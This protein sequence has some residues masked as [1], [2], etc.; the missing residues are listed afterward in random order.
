M[1]ADATAPMRR[2]I[3]R[4]LTIVAVAAVCAR[5]LSVERVYEPSIHREEP[6][7]DPA[8]IAL[9]LA[10]TSLLDTT[11]FVAAAGERWAWIDPN[12]PTRTWAHSRPAPS[13]TFSSNDRSRWAMVRALVDEGTF[14]I[15][16]RE[17]GPSGKYRDVGIVFEDGWQSIDKVLHPQTKLYYSSKPPLLPVIAAGEYWLLQKLFAWRIEKQTKRVVCTILLTIN[18]L[19][20]AIYLTVLARLIERYGRTDWG[21][22]F[23]FAA[24][25]FATYLTTFANTFNNHTVAA[26]TTLFAVAPLLALPAR[27]GEGRVGVS[28]TLPGR[29]ATSGFFAGLTACFELP[30]AAFLVALGVAALIIDWRRTL[31]AFV[32]AA[33][34][35]IAAHFALNYAELGDWK[36]AYE[37]IDSEW[38][39]YEGSHWNAQGVNRR[40]IDYAGDQESRPTYAF[41]LLL[42]HHGLFSLT[43]IW[44]LSAAGLT[45][46]LLARPGPDPNWRR[47]QWATAAVSVIVIVFFAAIVST[48]NYG[49]WTS[50]PRWFFWLTPLWL[51]ALLPAADR[52][53]TRAGR[54]VAYLALALSVFSVTFVGINP[55]RHP[56]VYQAMEAWGWKGY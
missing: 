48:V 47:V 26:Y 4:L 53:T 55:W 21:R 13:P 43:P 3:Y 30:A 15:G 51:L 29:F 50:G 10:A 19:P 33:L 46:T 56:W 25:C 7:P 12:G 24:A 11:I 41:H 42:G 27:V 31:L 17:Y 23:T 20:F 36:P 18:A 38:Y 1:N 14:A 6:P 16:R 5:I 40:G 28:W 2:N 44:L 37:K 32:P 52:V 34:I 9:P 45:T 39:R 35:P 8:A 54:F 22:L 49:G